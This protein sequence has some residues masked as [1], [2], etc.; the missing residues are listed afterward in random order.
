MGKQQVISLPLAID[1]LVV[2]TK[3]QK[4]IRKEAVQAIAKQRARLDSALKKEHNCGK[5]EWNLQLLQGFLCAKVA[6]R[7]VWAKKVSLAAI[8]LVA[9]SASFG[10][11]E[12]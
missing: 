4:I 5:G 9:G 12:N 1:Q 3:D 11:R 7:L 2:D 6:Y 8:C 10:T